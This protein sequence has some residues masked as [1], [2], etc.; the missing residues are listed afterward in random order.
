M[1]VLGLLLTAALPASAAEVT[2]AARDGVRLA[3]TY[4][5]SPAPDAPALVLLPMLGGRRSDWDGLLRRAASAGVS[6]LLVD[7]RGHGDSADPY[8]QPPNSWSKARWEAV[9]LDAAAAVAWL[10]GQGVPAGR[11]FI[12]GASV[13]ASVALRRAARDARL[14]GAVLV[15][16]GDNPA[17]V[18]A[19]AFIAGLGTRPIL[20]ASAKDDPHFDA[21]ADALA[22]RARGALD[23]VR[24]PRGGHG[25]AI[26]SDSEAGPALARV[27]LAWLRPRGERAP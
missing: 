2:L 4:L 14:A 16:P 20:I 1:T 25:T 3:A 10:E 27:L 8:G 15:S 22:R 6:M 7:P 26:F 18:P 12:G 21:V 23:R 24:L 13:G 19:S 5:Q 11:I 17:R 9:D